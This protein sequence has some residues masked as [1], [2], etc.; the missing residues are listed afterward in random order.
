MTIEID[1][2]INIAFFFLI[3]CN[4]RLKIALFTLRVLK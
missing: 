2:L 1:V 3:K 4:D